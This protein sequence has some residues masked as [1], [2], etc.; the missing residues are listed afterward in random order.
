MDVH[1]HTH[2]LATRTQRFAITFWKGK[3]TWKSLKFNKKSEERSQKVLT[4]AS[5]EGDDEKA[6]YASFKHVFIQWLPLHNML[7]RYFNNCYCSFFW[8]RKYPARKLPYVCLI[9]IGLKQERMS[10]LLSEI[11]SGFGEPDGTTPLQIP[12]NSHPPPGRKSTVFC[13]PP[14]AAQSMDQDLLLIYLPGPGLPSSDFVLTAPFAG[15]RNAHTACW[16]GYIQTLGAFQPRYQ[17]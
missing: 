6:Q 10:S 3:N 14:S 8:R 13:G 11:V 17:V 9:G 2:T 15:L 1:T 7:Y 5:L 12:S 16:V 4:V